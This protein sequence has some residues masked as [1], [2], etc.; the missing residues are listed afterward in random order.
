MED[1]AETAAGRILVATDCLSEG[2]NLQHLFTAVVHY[3]L[4]WNPT[5]HEQREG[6]VDRFGQQAPEV[7]CTML[8]GQDN[9]VDGFV[10]NVILRKGEA[11]QKELGV[12][13]PM[14]ED[15]QRI[16]QALVKAALMKRERAGASP[17]LGF[18]FAEAEQ[19]L[20]PLQTQWTDAL[21]KAKANRTVFAQRRIR[22]DEVLPEWQKQQT[23]LGSSRRRAALCAKRLRPPGRAAGGRAQQQHQHPPPPAHPAPARGPAPAPGRRRP[24]AR[25]RHPRSPHHLGAGL[26]R[27]APQPPPGERAGRPPAGKRPA[28]AAPPH[29]APPASPRAAPPPS[30]MRSMSSPPWC[31]CACATSWATCAAASPTR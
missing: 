22:P 21:E 30:P 23:A 16:N 14:P 26:C 24:G 11:I 28:K 3:D 9:P 6:R 18:D 15:K 19:L 5:R 8:Y 29:P 7:R 4:A 27:T 13:V 12:L 2:I 25:R 1:V 20:A 17:Q 10:L 31:C